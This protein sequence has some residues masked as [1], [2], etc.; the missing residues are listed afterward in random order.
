[1][2]LS[3]QLTPGLL[4]AAAGLGA[5]LLGGSHPGLALTGA[6]VGGLALWLRAFPVLLLAGLMLVAPLQ[7]VLAAIDPGLKV[8]DE[9]VVLL[10]SGLVLLHALWRTPRAV[11]AQRLVWWSLAF[12]GLGALSAWRQGAPAA[13]GAMGLLV[14]MDYVILALA[15]L[16]LQLPRTTHQAVIAVLLGLGVVAVFAG[17]AQHMLHEVALPDY[18]VFIRERDMLRVP[19][20]FRHPNDLAYLMLAVTFVAGAGLWL[21]GG[22]IYGL[23]ALLGAVGMLLAVSRSSYLALAVGVVCAA[24]FGGFA[25]K[26]VWGLLLVG[27]LLLAPLMAPGIISRVEK[28]QREGGDARFT[29]AQQGLRIVKEHPLLGVGPGQFGGVVAER[30]G[31]PVHKAFGIEFNSTWSTVDSYWLHLLVESGL[32][33]LLAMLGL[34]F[35]VC[36]RARQRLLQKQGSP[37]QRILCLAVLMLVPAHLVINLSSMALEANSTAAVLWLLVGLALSP[38]SSGSES[39]RTAQA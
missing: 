1:M 36:R 35:E 23:V 17:F 11:F 29:Y 28:I 31:S 7:P 21:R 4:A 25:S 2:T 8:Y 27:G 18:A 26:R 14:T 15:L 3:R 16:H 9:A 24:L 38:V 32:L 10:F 22:V 34:L 19:S 30:Y 20:L 39:A 12:M 33:G 6:V 13:Q 37:E 5:G